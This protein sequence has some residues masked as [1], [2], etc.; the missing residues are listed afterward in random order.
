DVSDT[1]IKNSTSVNRMAGAMKECPGTMGS[2][3]ALAARPRAEVTFLAVQKV[4]QPV[5]AVGKK[6]RHS[7]IPI[8]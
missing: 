8:K 2:V 4:T 3:A 1:Q 7:L 6:N 5:K